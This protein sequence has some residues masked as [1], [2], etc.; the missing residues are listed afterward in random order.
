MNR[1]ALWVAAMATAGT[2]VGQ[3]QPAAGPAADS[4]VAVAPSEGVRRADAVASPFNVK[5]AP[6]LFWNTLGL[7]AEVALSGSFTLGVGAYGKWGARGAGRN[8]LLLLDQA[9][10]EPGYLVELFGRYYPLQPAPSGW[11][12]QG[13]VSYGT[14]LNSDASTRPFTLFTVRDLAQPG[15]LVRSVARS[16]PYAF[17]VGTGYQFLIPSARLIVNLMGGAQMGFGAGDYG[18]AY[19]FFYAQPAVGFYF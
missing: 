17:G 2:L 14:L 4:T 1:W 18:G 15:S 3:P 13:N 11:Y 7:E 6:G 19:L 12:V 8:H 9:Y 10:F 5:L 16:K